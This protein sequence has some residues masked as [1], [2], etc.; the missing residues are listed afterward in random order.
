VRNKHPPFKLHFIHALKDD[1]VH[2]F[3]KIHQ[4]W[5]SIVEVSRNYLFRHIFL[6]FTDETFSSFSATLL[7]CC[8]ML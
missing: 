2:K 5:I 4:S 8:D 3:I 7:K 6:N 1:T